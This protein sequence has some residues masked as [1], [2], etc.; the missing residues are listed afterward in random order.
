[1]SDHDRADY[2]TRVGRQV[3]DFRTFV[4][5]HYMTER[6]DTP[7]WREVRANRIHPE[8]R[9][10]LAHWQQAM[11]RMTDFPDTLDG[12]PHIQT[13]LHYPVLEG[14]GLLNQDVARREMAANPQ[15][16]QFARETYE[17]LVKEYRVAGAQA[18][19]HREFLDIVNTMS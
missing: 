18:L 1:M 15:L 9:E 2:N 8:T 12:L 3:D 14:L 13:Q 5:T 7:F 4:N 16:R 11:P 6:D 19:G 17:S 10:R